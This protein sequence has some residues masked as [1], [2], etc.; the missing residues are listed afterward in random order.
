VGGVGEL[1]AIFDLSAGIG[2]A[3]RN[4]ANTNWPMTKTRM[5]AQPGK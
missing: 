4:D 2:A 3:G 5:A 1:C